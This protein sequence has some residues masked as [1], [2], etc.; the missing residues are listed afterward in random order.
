VVV[1][2]PSDPAEVR[3]LAAAVANER[4]WPE[5]WLNDAAKG[6]M[7]GISDGPVIFAAP[8]IE[9]CRPAIAQLLAMKLGAWRDD[10]DIADA[11]R[12]LEELSGGHDEVWRQIEPYLQPGRELKAQY[13]FDDLWEN[14]RGQT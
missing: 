14:V 13:A 12:L 6:F 2:P 1:L 11:R 7:V 5:D 10:L 8:G 3:A 4:G 9:V